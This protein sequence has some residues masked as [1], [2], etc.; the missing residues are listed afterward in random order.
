MKTMKKWLLVLFTALF[1]VFSCLGIAA[2]N[3]KTETTTKTIKLNYTEYVMNVGDSVQLTADT[4][5]AWETDN[6]KIASVSPNGTVVA[7]ALGTAKISAVG[8]NAK[9]TCKITVTDELLGEPTLSVNL[10]SQGIFIGDMLVCEATVQFGKKTVDVAQFGL[11]VTSSNQNVAT[12]DGFVINGVAE[13]E[14]DITVSFTYKGKDYSVTK[15][16]T[17]GNIVD[18]WFE[19]AEYSSIVGETFPVTLLGVDQGGEIDAEEVSWSVSDTSIVSCDNGTLKTLDNGS[20][21]LTATYKGVSADCVVDIYQPVWTSDEV[22]AILE[23]TDGNYILMQDID[24]SETKMKKGGSFSGKI[25][26]NGYALSGIRYNGR[27]MSMFSEFTGVVKNVEFKNVSFNGN[28]ALIR[29]A[30]IADY[31]LD[32]A[33]VENC[34]FDVTF[35]NIGSANYE[36]GAYLNWGFTAGVI[37]AETAGTVRVKD[38]Y[39]RLQTP[40]G[41]RTDYTGLVVGRLGGSVFL[42]NVVCE[43]TGDFVYNAAK[44]WA[45]GEIVP[46]G[47]TGIYPKAVTTSMATGVLGNAWDFEN[48]VSIENGLKVF[49]NYVPYYVD[50]EVESLDEDGYELEERQTCHAFVGQTVEN[51]AYIK[52][53]YGLIYDEA[54]SD[55]SLVVSEGGVLALRYTRKTYTVTLKVDNK[56]ESKTYRYEEY[57]NTDDFALTAPEVAGKV[58]IGW[59]DNADSAFEVTEDVIGGPVYATPIYTYDDF[60][61]IK[62]DMTGNYVLMNDIDPVAEKGVREELVTIVFNGD[63]SGILDGQGYAIKNITFYED[64]APWTQALGLFEK[65]SGTLKDIGFDN[66]RLVPTNAGSSCGAIARTFTG[67][68]KNVYANIAMTKCYYQ[69]NEQQYG[70]MFGTL[71]DGAVVRDCFI[72]LS[73]NNSNCYYNHGYVAG[74]VKGSVR[75]ENVLVI[76]GS[77]YA[78]LVSYQDPTTAVVQKNKVLIADEATIKDRAVDI[79]GK[80]WICDSVNFPRIK[81]P[82]EENIVSASTPYT[83]KYFFNTKDAPNKYL[84]NAEYRE[85]YKGVPGVQTDITEY[86]SGKSFAGYQLNTKRSTLKGVVTKDGKL[87]LEAYYTFHAIAVSTYDEFYSAVLNYPAAYIYLTNDIDPIAEKNTREQL[88]GSIIPSFVGVIDGQGYSISNV[89]LYGLQVEWYETLTMFQSFSGTIKNIALKNFTHS[90]TNIQSGN[91]IIAKS[92]TGTAENVYIDALVQKTAY[93]YNGQQYGTMFGTLGDGAV[94]KNCY[95]KTRILN[96]GNCTSAYGYLAGTVKGNVTIENIVAVTSSDAGALVAYCEGANVNGQACPTGA[97]VVDAIE[98]VLVATEAEAIAG[99]GAV[100]SEAWNCDGTNVPTL[101][102]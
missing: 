74:T 67:T 52:E 20:V 62:E 68:A 77:A 48:G 85:T 99:A 32:G 53:L 97:D 58:L 28:E 61:K 84:E 80:G 50:I 93:Q 64:N 24:M 4:V 17:V 69:Y 72:R 37:A 31:M 78:S 21:T 57:C 98:K 1:M 6:A 70:A 56:Q 15:K 82:G 42:E 79:L 60:L 100:L 26:G 66:F 18:V 5:C 29:T 54:N 91:G 30:L 75:I 101:H 3:N 47:A 10:K 65:V 25:D 55:E 23:Q 63:F 38:C 81:K 51:T 12:V 76:K 59:G 90:L 11:Q 41:A 88:W 46:M 71:E 83:I 34:Y 35:G 9:G 87:V 7:V 22:I 33:R 16:L 45:G 40:N 8:D 13:G 86:L 27:N 92:F 2:C 94:V 43:Q 96:N 95:I 89:V 36:W 44:E 73:S 14:T 49:N 39:I 102:K 19:Q